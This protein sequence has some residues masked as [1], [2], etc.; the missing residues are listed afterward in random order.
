MQKME[1]E[2]E[3]ELLMVEELGMLWPPSLWGHDELEPRKSLP[4]L[5]RQGLSSVLRF[6]QFLAVS[7]VRRPCTIDQPKSTCPLPAYLYLVCSLTLNKHFS[8]LMS[9]AVVVKRYQQKW[10]KELIS[11]CG[12]KEL[13]YLFTIKNQMFYSFLSYICGSFSSLIILF[14]AQF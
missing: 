12:S 5:M 14:G 1:L 3:S 2:H 8:V 6:S 13:S 7:L 4:S 11:V 10:E 9:P